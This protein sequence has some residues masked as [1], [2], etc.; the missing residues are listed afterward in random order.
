MSMFSE[1]TISNGLE[2]VLTALALVFVLDGLL[3]AIMPNMVKRAMTVAT[4]I[5]PT[6]F[7]MMGT[8]MAI[9]GAAVIW[10]L[11]TYY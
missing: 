9:C 6:R 5:P 2:V 10:M 7:R 4:S 1:I 3:Y 8:F 11:R